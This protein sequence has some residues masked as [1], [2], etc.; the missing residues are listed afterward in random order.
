MAS[1]ADPLR[2]ANITAP[3]PPSSASMPSDDPASRQRRAA[4]PDSRQ[5]DSD[6]SQPRSVH[7]RTIA[8]PASRGFRR[9]IRDGPG[10]GDEFFVDTFARRLAPARDDDH[11]LDVPSR[12]RVARRRP[13]A[14]PAYFLPCGPVSNGRPTLRRPLFSLTQPRLASRHIYHPPPPASYAPPH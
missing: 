7:L 10:G 2:T 14:L 1:R 12:R 4:P 3:A 5:H 13:H 11:H 6:R 8:R 9:Q